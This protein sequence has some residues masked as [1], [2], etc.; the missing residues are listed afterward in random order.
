MWGTSLN[1]K[2]PLIELDAELKKLDHLTI[3]AHEAVHLAYP[4][5]SERKVIAGSKL[6]ASIIWSQNYRRVE[7]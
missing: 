1:A 2:E 5:M 3:L 6:I 4:N 7:Q